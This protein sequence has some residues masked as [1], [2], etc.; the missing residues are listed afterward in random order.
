MPPPIGLISHGNTVRVGRGP[1]PTWTKL[2]GVQ[3]VDVPEPAP[4]DLDATH[5]DSGGFTEENIP[6]LNAAIDWPLDMLYVPGSATDAALVALNARDAN[7]AKE[8]HLLE[9]TVGGVAHTYMVYLKTYAPK[10]PLK[11]NLM[12]NATWRVMGR[13]ANATP[14]APPEDP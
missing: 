6:G 9:I 1:T 4:A 13:V 2:V 7:G 3:N 11:G 8:F 14:P 10:G 12:A 5:Q